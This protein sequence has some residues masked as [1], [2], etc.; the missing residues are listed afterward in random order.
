MKTV[1]ILIFLFFSAFGFSQNELNVQVNGIIN[2]HGDLFVGLYNKSEGFTKL[3]AVY[4]YK[5]EEIYDSV[6]DVSFTD[7]PDGKYAV[8]V[9][10]DENSN[11][12]L[13]KNFVGYPN[14]IYGF[15]NNERAVFSA[16][17]YEDCAFDL[18][19]NKSIKISLK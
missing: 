15:S 2:V 16:P 9:F 5:I 12:I 6:M 1:H 3:N 7:L 11:G 17:S 18:F 10:H 8:S 14:E 13:D 4:K 19:R